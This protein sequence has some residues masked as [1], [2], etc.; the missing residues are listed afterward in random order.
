MKCALSARITEMFWQKCLAQRHG[1]TNEKNYIKAYDKEGNT[2]LHLA[3]QNGSIE[4][5]YYEYSIL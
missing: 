1:S 5:S 4:V 2:A 3:V